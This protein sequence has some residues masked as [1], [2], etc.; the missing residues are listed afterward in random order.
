MSQAVIFDLDGVLVDSFDAHLRSWMALAARTGT[1]I[2]P[3]QFAQ[4]FGLTSRDIIR[5]FWG[6]DLTEGRIQELDGWKERRYRRIVA[7]GRPIMDGVVNC[8]L[9]QVLA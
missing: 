8:S 6:G 9:R 4:T 7:R 5:R 1:I 2:G 3:S